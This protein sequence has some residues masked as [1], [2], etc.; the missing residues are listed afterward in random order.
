MTTVTM[1]TRGVNT[2]HP[3]TASIS[4]RS[5][6]LNPSA[7]LSMLTRTHTPCTCTHTP[8]TRT[9]HTHLRTHIHIQ[10][11][12]TR[13]THTNIH[14]KNNCLSIF[15]S[16]QLHFNNP[17]KILIIVAFLLIYLY[18]FSSTAP[19]RTQTCSYTT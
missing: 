2:S 18:Y 3:P 1:E 12:P 16:V 14:W 8:C 17:V 9:H 11:Y 5:H 10:P 19:I 15:N 6:N 4:W 13:H 7:Q